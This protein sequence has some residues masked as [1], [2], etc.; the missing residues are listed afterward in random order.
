MRKPSFVVLASVVL[1]SCQDLPS[2]PQIE[3]RSDTSLEQDNSY[4]VVLK[5]GSGV[6][7]PIVRNMIGNLG[8]TVDYT[9]TSALN[10]YA[11]HL[12][13]AAVATLRARPDVQ[14][15]E[16]DEVMTINSGGVQASAVWG[17]DRLDQARAKETHLEEGFSL[18]PPT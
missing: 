10:G 6:P 18:L 16:R 7:T 9:Y 1:A 13:D 12:S 15:V 3:K 2:S 11:A 17:L 8:G 14:L 4:I 5:P